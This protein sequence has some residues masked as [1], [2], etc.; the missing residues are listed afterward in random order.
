M[1]VLI[2]Y[3][4]MRVIDLTGIRQL[5]DEQELNNIMPFVYS[6]YF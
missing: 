4:A 1:K 3:S 6:K 2:I 5:E